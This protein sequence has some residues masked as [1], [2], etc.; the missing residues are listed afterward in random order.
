MVAATMCDVKS[1]F[2]NFHGLSPKILLFVP[3]SFMASFVAS[4]NDQVFVVP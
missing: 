4:E 2:V 3:V 1:V